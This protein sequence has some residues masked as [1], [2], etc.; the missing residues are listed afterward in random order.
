[1]LEDSQKKNDV[2]EFHSKNL[3]LKCTWVVY[4]NIKFFKKILSY[5]DIKEIE[6]IVLACTASS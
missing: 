2:L 4:H 1:V 3:K 6:G 5:H